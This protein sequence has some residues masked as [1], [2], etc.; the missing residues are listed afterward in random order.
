[1][2]ADERALVSVDHAATDVFITA[3]GAA[4]QQ[5]QQ[6]ARNAART[7]AISA[8]DPTSETLRRQR[9]RK[10]AELRRRPSPP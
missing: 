1:M 5:D 8:P 3:S 7:S 10:S 2:S 6:R 4:D 9:Q